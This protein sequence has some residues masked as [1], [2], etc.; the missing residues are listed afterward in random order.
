MVFREEIKRNA[1]FQENAK[2][3][4]DSREWKTVI[5]KIKQYKLN[6]VREEQECLSR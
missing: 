6:E 3:V 2:L 4:E 1:D 5:G